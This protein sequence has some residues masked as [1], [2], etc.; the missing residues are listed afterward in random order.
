MAYLIPVNEAADPVYTLGTPVFAGSGCPPRSVQVIPSEDGQ[1]ISILFSDYT[2]VTSATRSRTRTSCNLALPIKALPG[3]S[4]GLFQIDYRG[5][6]YVP[7]V[8]NSYADFTTEYFFAG[9]Q[10]EKFK[11]FYD[12]GFNGDI[13][14]SNNVGIASVVWSPCG[15]NTN[16]RVNSAITAFKPSLGS[17]DVQIA[18]DTLDATVSGEVQI[19]MTYQT[20]D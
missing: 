8:P 10:G 1:S 20:C 12:P 2:A 11:R 3:F 19:H 17:E 18:I 4:L 5:Y 6:A 14:E 15:A 13:L 7:A 16:F 9:K